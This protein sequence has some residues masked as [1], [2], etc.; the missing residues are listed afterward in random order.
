MRLVLALLAL[1]SASPSFAG[2]HLSPAQT[3]RLAAVR[4]YNPNGP[5]TS[6][7]GDHAFGPG[8]TLA[9]YKPAGMFFDQYHLLGA[10]SG[11]L[12]V[13]NT[14]AHTLAFWLNM[15]RQSGAQPNV[16]NGGLL[17]A[18]PFSP[19]EA[20]AGNAPGICLSI[21]SSSYGAQWNFNDSTGTTTGATKFAA[22]GSAYMDA[23][24][25]SWHH[26]LT[27][28]DNTAGVWAV[29]VDGVN[30]G[31]TRAA[32]NSGNVP[33]FNNALGWRF[34]N[35]SY[36]SIN[37]SAWASEIYESNTSVVCTG[38]GAPYTDCAGANTIPPSV[39]A[40]FVSGSGASA[41]PVNM[42]TN[43]QLVTGTAPQV[44]L[45]GAMTSNTGTATNPITSQQMTAVAYTSGAFTTASTSI[46]MTTTNTLGVAAGW[47]MY[48]QT[49]NKIL[50]TVAAWT[51]YTITLQGTG[52]PA[53]AGGSGDHIY[54]YGPNA[55]PGPP[56][57][58]P[59]GM[60]PHQATLKW[61]AWTAFTPAAS[62]NI[63][64]SNNANG[65]ASGD[66][67]LL[68]VGYI[69]GSSTPPTPECPSGWS[70]AGSAVSSVADT[71]ILACWQI[72]SSPTAAGSALSVPT[73]TTA[74]ATT[75]AIYY[76]SD[77]GA[78]AGISGVDVSGCQ[79]DSAGAT[80]VT[81]PLTTTY[82][83][84]TLVSIAVNYT[85][86]TFSIAG[87]ATQWIEA[88]R[89]TTVVAD[90]VLTAVGSTQRTWSI[91]PNYPNLTCSVAITPN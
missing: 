89:P 52:F 43:C 24:S 58:G 62:V 22:P 46:G 14:T 19:C 30:A 80:A 64:P 77:Y 55:N 12:G 10:T 25:G 61:Q 56:P 8:A 6:G 91:T 90:E 31:W 63:T 3:M 15:S 57:F 72:A 36:P 66:L 59:G 20:T 11:P 33:D 53:Y 65:I 85:W 5:L 7:G 78:T 37:I 75:Q 45:T 51:S 28:F 48:D 49:I 9:S 4:T 18:V 27:S 83:N 68:L 13:T 73:I 70:T 67:L 42:G 81:P 17:V 34:M 21:D 86:S 79:V 26:F 41:K 40:K 47:V 69:N 50:G 29:Y 2:D 76:M 16:L 87:G 60:N 1:I 44:C 54:F 23:L 39:L 38:V 74:G 88:G 71:S 32:Y 82:A 84:D 35:G